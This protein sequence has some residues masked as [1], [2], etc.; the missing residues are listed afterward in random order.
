MLLESFEAM[1]LQRRLAVSLPDVS[2]QF[3]H[4][5]Q[6]Q[7]TIGTSA[8]NLFMFSL[9]FLRGELFTATEIVEKG[10]GKENVEM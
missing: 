4:G 3:G 2:V 8:M 6:L 9:F 1:L 5:G 7:K 10:K